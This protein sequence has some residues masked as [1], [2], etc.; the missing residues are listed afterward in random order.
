MDRFGERLKEARKMLGL[1]QHDFGAIGGVAANAQGRYENGERLPKSDY[2]M[3]IRLKGVD[4]LY[5]LTG[6]RTALTAETLS[7]EEA[8][9]IRHY[10][11][12]DG[13][14][15]DALAQLATSLSEC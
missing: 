11:T 14:D 15:Q 7:D 9:I 6:E 1:S 5:V 3:A 8:V 2:L 4:V 13:V 12:L 10:R